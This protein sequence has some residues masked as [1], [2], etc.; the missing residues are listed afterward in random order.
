MLTL[1]YLLGRYPAICYEINNSD[2]N[3]K[4]LKDEKSYKSKSQDGLI[5]TNFSS[6]LFAHFYSSPRRNYVCNQ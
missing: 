6:V 5:P 1:S 2:I 4:R 3:K